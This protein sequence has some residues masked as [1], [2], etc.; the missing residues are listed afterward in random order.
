MN[1]TPSDVAI[2]VKELSKR[3][4]IYPTPADMLWELVTRRCRHTE[5]WALR[6]VSFEVP[7][8]EVVGI[9]G[10]NGAGKSTL[11]KIITGTLE[12]TTGT[13]DVNGRVSSILELGTGFH[14]EYTGRENVYTGGMC[15]GMSRN[16]IDS[17]ID[18][19]IEFS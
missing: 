3:F 5:F 8:G 4:E 18:Q 7:A 6:D 10:R 12:K 13:V 11:L 17:K 1:D 19:I 9:M 2:R 14:P 15:L 16:E